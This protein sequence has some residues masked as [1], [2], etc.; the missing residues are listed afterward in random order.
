MSVSADPQRF[1]TAAEREAFTDAAIPL[2]P[3]ESVPRC[4]LCGAERAAPFTSGRDYELQTCRNEWHFVECTECGLVR[5]NPRPAVAALPTIYPSTYYAYRYDEIPW[6]ARTAK[7]L[8]DRRKLAAIT[9]ALGRP[10]RSFADIGCG[11][12]RYLRAMHA[13]GVPKADIHGLE[14]DA[15]VVRRLRAEGFQAHHARVE[16]CTAIAP[17][18]LDLA[19][20]FH[21]IEHVDSPATVIGRVAEWMAPGGLFALETPNL[22]SWDARR[23]RDRWW[24][25]YHIPRHWTLFTPGTLVRMLEANGFSPVAVRWQTGHSFWM[26]SFHHR[27]RYGAR[28]RPRLAARFDPL[29]NV[30]TLAAFTALDLLRGA[31][32]VPTSAMLVLA[33]RRADSPTTPPANRGV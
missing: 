30:A 29:R 5:L 15:D 19:T 33:R 12:G 3:T 26:Y 21:V 11:S 20:M 22:E 7:T 10:V 27:L 4:D 13:A 14:L 2:I 28:P 31:V 32:G 24:G 17:A 6:L 25:G 16:D 23:F 18:S 9:R 1:A 8:L